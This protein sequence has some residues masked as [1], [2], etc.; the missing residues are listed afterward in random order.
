L[1]ITYSAVLLLNKD[2]ALR[3]SNEA[4]RKWQARVP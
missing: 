1:R 3:N 2:S 4:R